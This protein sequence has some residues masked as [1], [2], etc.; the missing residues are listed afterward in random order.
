MPN[1]R[2]LM[3]IK[4]KYYVEK[5]PASET[6]E[7]LLKK[8]YAHR[9]PQIMYSFGLFDDNRI[10]QGVCT[11]G[12]TVNDQ[13]CKCCGD[14]FKDNVIEL[15][16]LIKN[17]GLE[18]NLQSFFISK[19]FKLLTTPIIII[20]YSDPNFNHYGYTYQALNFY[21]TGLAGRYREFV[22]QNKIYTDRHIKKKW[23][24]SKHLNFKDK[25]DIKTN[26]INNGGKIIYKK[27]KHRYIYFL[28]NKKEKK[29]M[30][31]NLKYPILPYPKGE[32]K[33]YDTGKD[34]ITQG[35]LF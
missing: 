34:I 5:I 25:D 28:G 29:E 32:N 17:D 9:I 27:K 35:V 22:Y 30:L 21:Y 14:K 11:F 1:R 8:H 10:L 15:N 2:W 6:W 16:R 24:I 12:L 26:F 31:K 23:F 19:C 3:S 33:R 4:D 7:W 13:I 20:S 18:K